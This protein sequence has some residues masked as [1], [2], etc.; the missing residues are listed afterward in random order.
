MSYVFLKNLKKNMKV[1][2]LT[3][4]AGVGDYDGRSIDEIIVGIARL[5][6]SREVN[7]LFEEPDKL[8]R[9]CLWNSHWSIFSM[10]NLTFEIETS[11]A[12]G[13]E[14]L[15]HFSLSPQELSQRYASVSNSEP[16]E[17]REQ[18]KNNRQSSVNIIDPMMYQD[19]DDNG[20]Y[21]LY[22]SQL[23]DNHIDSSHKLYQDLQSN[24]VA[25]ESARFVLPENTQTTLIM[26]GKIRDWI[27][28]LNQRLHHT[29]Q[30]EARQVA[31]AIRDIFIQ[32]CPIISKML[33]NFEDAD[34][35][36]ILE[37]IL[38]EKWGV[39]D[40]IKDNGFKKIKS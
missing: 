27:T 20:P 40:Q 6:S 38:L 19:V 2:L 36:H 25:R 8:L 32:E 24:G 39:Y 3:K 33:F 9:H 30:K 13:R 26:N 10:A 11:R 16:I 18:C 21:T 23:I 12:I 4:T 14:Y 22:A 17:I 37:R 15:R 31:E 1:K 34:K 28:T 7:E 35:I 29:A 5:S